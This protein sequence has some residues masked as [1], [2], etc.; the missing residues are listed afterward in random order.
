M[1]SQLHA[2]KSGFCTR[3]SAFLLKLV[4]SRDILSCRCAVL[5]EA[6]NP[7]QTIQAFDLYCSVSSVLKWGHI[8]PNIDNDEDSIFL[9]F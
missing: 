3:V 1:P 5:P 4:K 8:V 9:W 2:R 7:S 6:P